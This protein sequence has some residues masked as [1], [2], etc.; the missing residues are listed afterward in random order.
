MIQVTRLN[1][2]SIVLNCDLIEQ[3]ESTPDTVITLT[4]NQKL[5]VLETAEE[6]VERIR[7]YR[8]SILLP[9]VLGDVSPTLTANLSNRDSHG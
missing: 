2:C 4:N 9:R 8:R 6:I 3:I 5:T 7:L 1:H